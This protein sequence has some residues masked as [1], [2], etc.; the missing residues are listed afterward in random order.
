[1]IWLVSFLWLW[2]QSVC[3]LIPSLSTY[4]LIGAS[5][6]LDMRYL[7]TAAPAK[8]SCCS[9]PWTWGISSWPLLL[10]LDI[11]Y[12]FWLLGTP[13]PCSHGSPLQHR[14]AVDIV[15]EYL[16][17]SITPFSNL[18]HNSHGHYLPPQHLYTTQFYLPLIF[19]CF[20]SILHGNLCTMKQCIQ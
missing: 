17:F 20:L 15:I 9:L 1:M 13:A 8:H 11:G 14:T 7:F 6:T 4:C 19:R 2:F 10:T 16:K 5:L 12:L 3:P 18:Q